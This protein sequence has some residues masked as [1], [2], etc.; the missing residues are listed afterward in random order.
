MSWVCRPNLEDRMNRKPKDLKNIKKFT[1]GQKMQ[2][3]IRP[4]NEYYCF[5]PTFGSILN[6]NL[7]TNITMVS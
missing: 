4:K 6:C 2:K 3:N 5:E 7:T 1:I